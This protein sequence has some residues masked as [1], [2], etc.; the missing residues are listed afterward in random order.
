MAPTA[1]VKVPGIREIGRFTKPETLLP[2][3]YFFGEDTHTIDSAVNL[4]ADVIKPLLVSEFDKEVFSA[5]KSTDI[6]TILDAASAFPFGSGK[7]LIVV[8]NIELVKDIKPLAGYAENPPD[9]TILVVTQYKKQD[10]FSAE[11]YKSLL[12][13][14]FMFE[15]RFL[16]GAEL[17][18]WLVRRAETDGYV[19][20]HDDSLA[21]IDIS[22]EEK[23]FLEMQLQKIYNYIG[24]RKEITFEDIKFVSSSGKQYSIFD[25]YDAIA[26]VDKSKTMEAGYVLLENGTEITSIIAGITRYITTVAHATELKGK[27]N[28]GQAAREIEVAFRFYRSALNARYFFHKPNLHKAAQALMNAD[29]MVK[30]TQ[31]DPRTIFTILITEMFA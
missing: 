23:G 22:G 10:K 21:L 17:A 6:N 26:K 18:E 7:K 1:K 19:L 16:K 11:P 4:L 3:Y 30:T 14:N 9:F 5:D 27:M 13:N 12:K 25:L 24:S 8:K 2:V 15:A 20:N 28:E 29:T 31:A